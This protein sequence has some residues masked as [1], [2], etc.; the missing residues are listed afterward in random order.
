MQKSRD[1]FVLTV[2]LFDLEL[3][4]L[5]FGPIQK[6]PHGCPK[7]ADTKFTSWMSKMRGGS[8]P[9]LDNVQ[10]KEA[11]LYGFP[12]EEQKMKDG[13]PLELLPWLQ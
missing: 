12:E 13:R 10:K 11:F 6:L 3:I 8:R 9:L 2:L 7:W 1:G 4:Y 5:D